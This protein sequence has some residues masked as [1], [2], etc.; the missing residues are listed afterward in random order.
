VETFTAAD[1]TRLAEH[2]SGSG[3]RIVCIPG[4]PMMDPAH[5]G[6]LGGL[7]TRR[8]LVRLDLRG[9]GES[10]APADPASYRCDRQA[11]DV[12]ALRVA[13]GR[14]R[15]V[16]CGHWAGPAR[17][18]RRPARRRPLPLGRRPHPVPRHADQ[19]RV[20]SLPELRLKRHPKVER[21]MERSAATR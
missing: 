3:R 5:L 11:D 17:G 19:V 2:E 1:G 13:L 4:G 21:S 20:T 12:E 9:T 6:D 7:P 14:E 15:I 8:T 18:G 10:A 16:L